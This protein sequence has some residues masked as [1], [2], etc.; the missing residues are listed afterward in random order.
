M[1][2][3]SDRR[4]RPAG[5]TGRVRSVLTSEL[6]A[7]D[8]TDLRTL[9][10]AAWPGGRFDEH[11]F[12]HA[13]G[14]RHWLVEQD[15]RIVSHVSVVERALYVG[16]QRLRAGYLEAVATLPDHERRGHGTA[17]VQAAAEF[18][19]QAFELGALSTG[20]PPFYERL[21]WVRWLGPT[22]VRTSSGLV[23]TDGDH[24]GILV[25]RTPASP[26]LDLTAPISCDWRPG[27]AW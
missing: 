7:A 25:L 3:G 1:D 13:M 27:D 22:F 4:D 23:S 9:F 5:V 18:V 10:A 8:L 2:E 26:A 21:G 16:G 24:G 14:G 11:D 19:K 15:G 17:V 6:I 12:D 20:R